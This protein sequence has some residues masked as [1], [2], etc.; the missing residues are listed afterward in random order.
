MD[1]WC[2]LCKRNRKPADHFLLHC[3]VACAL[4]NEI[5]RCIGMS[6]VMHRQVVDLFTC[7]RGTFGSIQ[8]ATV[9][10][11]V[12]AYLLWCL[13][14]KRNY[15]GFEDYKRTVVKQSLFSLIL[16]IFKQLRMSILVF[17]AFM[18]FLFFFLLL[19]MSFLLYTSYVP[20]LHFLLFNDFSITL[21][22]KIKKEETS[23]NPLNF[24]SF[25]HHSPYNLKTLN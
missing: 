23:K 7:Q 11:M 9:Q 1:D 19:A 6:Q 8:F 20:R 21:K 13:Q 22:I 15:I 25:Q 4:Y 12:P 5:F 3:E 17:L 16:F 18:T 14:R 10:K 2:C 24:Y